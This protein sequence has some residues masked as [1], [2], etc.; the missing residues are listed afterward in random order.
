MYRMYLVKFSKRLQN[1]ILLAG[2]VEWL[3][4]LCAEGHQNDAGSNPG[5]AIRQLENSLSAQ[6]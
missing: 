4:G 3:E 2:V 5:R 1:A 6:Q